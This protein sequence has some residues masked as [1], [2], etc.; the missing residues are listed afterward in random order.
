M[1]SVRAV[2]LALAAMV[3]LAGCAGLPTSSTVRAQ[4]AISN[5]PVPHPPVVYPNP[6]QPGE[7]PREIVRDFLRA[8]SSPDEDFRIARMYLT[9]SASNTWDPSG[10]PVTVTTTEQQYN[11]TEQYGAPVRAYAKGVATLDS[12]GQMTELAGHQ[13]VSGSFHLDK[14]GGEWRISSL[15]SDFGAWISLADFNRLFTSHQVY[16]ADTVT[17]TLVPDTRWYLSSGGEATAL[18]RAVLG[19]APSWMQGMAHEGMPAGTRLEVDA[20]PINGDGLAT[21]DLSDQALQADSKTRRATWAA[22]MA[23]LEQLPSVHTVRLTVGGSPLAVGQNTGAI[24]TPADLGYGQGKR[25]SSVIITRNGSQLGWVDPVRRT[26]KPNLVKPPAGS[27]PRLPTLNKNWT[28]VSAS[29]DGKIVA[30]VSGDHRSLGLW[31]HRHLTVQNFGRDLVKPTFT[32]FGELWVAGEA[33]STAGQ[34]RS[35]RTGG[36]VVWVIDTSAPA[37][38]A[39]PQ[40]VSAPWLGHRQVL[41]MKASPEGER[42]ALVVRSASGRTEL[43]LSG[44]IRDGKRTP[45]A[46]STPTRIARPVT[47]LRDVT[48]IDESTVAVLGED[49]AGSAIQPVMVPLGGLVTAMGTASGATSIVGTGTGGAQIYAITDRGT[50]LQRSGRQWQEFG[51]GSAVIVPGA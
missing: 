11:V 28:F 41:A 30:A 46:L 15:P 39:K 37:E 9:A 13:N 4:Q 2:L 34:S 17:H 48:W 26:G 51:S 43:M 14:V 20:V 47:D 45:I 18:A 3:A 42:M 5:S 32:R 27:R 40:V 22:M 25:E 24:A 10:H 35:E 21:V 12:T 49:P 16:F 38:R 8:N 6:P 29:H 23:T 31:A 44:I 33:L 36:G 19:P 1:R 7:S 50:V